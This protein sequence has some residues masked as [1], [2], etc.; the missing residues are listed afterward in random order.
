MEVGS[1]PL[2][3][4]DLSGPPWDLC[5]HLM[6]LDSADLETLGPKTGTPPGVQSEALATICSFLA[7]HASG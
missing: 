1:G 3:I 7:S 2:P 6:L 5:S 4:I